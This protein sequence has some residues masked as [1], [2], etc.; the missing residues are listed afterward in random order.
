MSAFELFNHWRNIKRPER[1]WGLAW[2]LA[3]EFCQRYYC[4]HGLVPLV[5]EHEGLGYYGMQLEAVRCKVKSN[6]DH[7]YGRLTMGGDVENWRSGSPGDHGLRTMGMCSAKI[8]T[9]EIVQKAIAYMD[10]EAIPATSHIN[11]RHKRWGASYVMCFEI[12]TILALRNES[13]EMS[14]WNHPFH[15]EQAIV[16]IDSNANINEHPGGFLFTRGKKK[17]LLSGDG[18]L[19]D[20]S[21]RNLWYCFMNGYGVLYLA[22]LI[23]ETI[24]E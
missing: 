6:I 15:T 21:E 23:Q 10:I 1:S 14:I 13:E 11:C 12:A 19:L 7:P 24:D 9:E 16:E 18:R 8:S 4:S 22:D 3:Y 20:G 2:F 5:I 17:L